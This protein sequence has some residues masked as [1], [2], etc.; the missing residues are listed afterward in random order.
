MRTPS[1]TP[2]LEERLLHPARLGSGGHLEE[3]D[4]RRSITDA[5]NHFLRAVAE[6]EPAVLHDLATVPYARFRYFTE[7]AYKHPARR[8]VVRLQD[9]RGRVRVPSWAEMTAVGG[10]SP[11]ADL[12]ESLG[13]WA[14]RWHL[15]ALWCLERALETLY[16]WDH[17]ES[18]GR[19][20]DQDHLNWT[21][22][23]SP[24]FDPPPLGDSVSF[25]YD[26]PG[27][28]PRLLD[29]DDMERLVIKDLTRQVTTYFDAIRE[30]SRHHHL[31][32]IPAK[33]NRDHFIWAARWQV[34]GETYKA[35]GR[36]LGKDRKTIREAVQEVLA[37][38]QLPQRP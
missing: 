11:E 21:P 37:L 17:D 32:P 27:F 26:L 14:T 13:A 25:S 31:V 16:W 22:A 10:A 28:D 38:I 3:E 29:I 6:I 7:E 2:S 9:E 1:S 24:P 12:C 5:Q 30:A 15:T 35:L 8:P 34:G 4:Q 19:G 36:D 20:L 18:C 33:Y 23:V